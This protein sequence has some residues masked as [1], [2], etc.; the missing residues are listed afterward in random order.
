MF[1]R[2]RFNRAR[3][4]RGIVLTASVVSP[5]PDPSTGTAARAATTLFFS[6]LHRLGVSAL[7][8][9]VTRTGVDANR[10]TAVRT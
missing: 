1:D 6:T 5:G 7:S 10:S 3:F 2:I 8:S 9:S 4:A